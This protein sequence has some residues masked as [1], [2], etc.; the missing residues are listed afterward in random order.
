MIKREDIH[1]GVLN[2]KNEISLS[3]LSSFERL[4]SEES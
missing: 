2:A 3:S 4:I 1:P